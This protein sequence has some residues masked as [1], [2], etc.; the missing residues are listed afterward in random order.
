MISREMLKFFFFCI[1]AL[2]GGRLRW[3]HLE[4]IRLTIGRKMDDT[5]MFAHWRIDQPW[6]SVT[7]KGQG[8]RMGGGKGPIDHYVFP[9]KAQR[10]IVEVGGE[11]EFEEIKGILQQ[12]ARI[13]PFK[14]RVVSK[15]ILA[16]E[17]EQQKLAE[18]KNVNPYSF[19][20]C[21]KNNILGCRIW[22]S[23]YDHIWHGKYR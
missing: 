2:Q 12:V 21:S 18:S 16:E 6:Q 7:K 11:C 4:M 3:G 8:H 10:I 5:R 13:L 1:Q 15:T 14:A 22:L 20:Y 9:L 19:K 17:K 23:P